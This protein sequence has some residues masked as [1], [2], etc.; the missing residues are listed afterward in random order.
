MESFKGERYE[1][2]IRDRGIRSLEASGGFKFDV[3]SN[4]GVY[5]GVRKGDPRGF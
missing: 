4:G 5:S 3:G 1:I 2:I